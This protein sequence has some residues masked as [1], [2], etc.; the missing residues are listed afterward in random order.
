MTFTRG[1]DTADLKYATALPDQVDER[2]ALGVPAPL[3]QMDRGTGY[4]LL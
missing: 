3:V 1:L 4:D 2:M